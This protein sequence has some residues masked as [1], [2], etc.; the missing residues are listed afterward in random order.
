MGLWDMVPIGDQIV[1]GLLHQGASGTGGSGQRRSNDGTAL[2]NNGIFK[3]CKTFSPLQPPERQILFFR[4]ALPNVRDIYLGEAGAAFLSAVPAPEGLKADYEIAAEMGA[5]LA[6]WQF[7]SCIV[8]VSQLQPRYPSTAIDLPITAKTSDQ[9]PIV[10]AR[11]C[12][13]GGRLM[14]TGRDWEFTP[15]S[16]SGRFRDSIW[17]F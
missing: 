15:T 16:S 11:M 6:A 12:I 9:W 4:V 10:A 3:L 7:V 1:N 2:E 13:F 17:R 14:P 8:G 5:E